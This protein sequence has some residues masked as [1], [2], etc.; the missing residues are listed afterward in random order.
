MT[1]N[2]LA[3]ALYLVRAYTDLAYTHNYVF[4]YTYGGMVYATQARDLTA[5]QL[6]T[7]CS[8]SKA[9]R[10]AG[11]ALRFRPTTAQKQVLLSMGATTLCSKRYFDEL[12]KSSKYNKGENAEMLVTEKMFGQTW[13]KDSVPFT[14]AGDIEQDGIAWQHKHEG[15]TFCNERSLRHL[16]K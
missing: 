6:L 11:Y 10:G 2:L 3:I 15:A 5:E 12:V 7:V 8:V 16:A 4:T 14:Q 9:S 1:A 13:E